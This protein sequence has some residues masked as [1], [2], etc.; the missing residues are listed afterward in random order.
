MKNVV[1]LISGR[2]SNMQ[3]IVNAQ[4]PNTRI[5]A[6]LSNS[7]SAAGLAWAAELGIPTDSLNHKSFESRLA[8]D[9]AMMAKI[10]AYQP[11][12]VVLAGFMRILTPEFCVHYEGRLMNIHPSILPSFTGL[13][14]HER[15]LEAGCRVAGCTI[16][17]VTAELDCGPIIAQGVVPILDNDTADD[18]A[19]RVLCVEHQLF[20]KAVADFVAGR[21][22]IQGNRV[23]NTDSQP[24][25][26]ALLV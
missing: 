20:P 7:E 4:I 22:N 17:F 21:L 18:V 16:H 8:F 14:T 24:Q 11:D 26:S 1:I 12:L 9:Q 25:S 3:A 6:V 15:A 13:H 19:A 10:D 23:L 5:A 2:G